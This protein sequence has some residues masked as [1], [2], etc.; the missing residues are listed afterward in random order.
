MKLPAFVVFAALAAA[1]APAR[2]HANLLTNGDFADGLNGWT[3]WIQRD[4]QSDFAATVDTGRLSVAGSDINGGAYQQFDVTP[5]WVVTVTG[6]WHSAPAV[7]DA[8]WAEVLVINA[9]RTPV[10]GVDETGGVNDAILLYKNDTFAGRPA[11]D[12]PIPRTSPV[13]YQISFT[14][15]ASKAT[16]VLKTGNVGPNTFTGVLFDNLE[17]RA[18]PPPATMSDLP[19]GFTGRTYTFPVSNMTSIAQSPVSRHIYAIS[20]EASATNTRLY[21][22]ETDGPAITA[23]LVPGLGNLVDNAQGLTFDPAGNLYISTQFGKIIKGIDTHP[24]PAIDAFAFSTIVTMPPLQIGT[25]HGVGGV[26]VGPD[27]LL[28]INSGS[29]S[30]YGFLSDGSAE[31]FEGRLNARILRCN[32]DGSGLETFCEGIRNSFDITFRMDGKLFGVENGPN[33]GCDYAD[34]FN[35]LEAGQHYGFPYRY[36]SDVSGSDAS[37]TCTSVGTPGPPPLPDGLATTPAWANYGPDGKPGPGELGYADGGP[38]HGFHPHSSPNGL[39]FYEPALMDPGAILFP[40]EFHGRAFVARFGNLEPVP[41]VGF[42]VLTLRLDEAGRGFT[43]NRF[44]GG[45]GRV[46][47]VLCAYN[48]K[49]YV[50]EYNQE[51]VCCFG[52][53]GTPSRLYEIAYTVPTVPLIGLSTSALVRSVDYTQNLPDDTFTVANTGVGTVHFTASSDQAW[54]AVSPTNGSSTGPGDAVTLTLS[55]S[56]AALAIGTH[57]AS[58]TIADPGAANSPQVLSV[59]LT[60]KSVR[61]DFDLDSDVDLEDFAYLQRCLGPILGAPPSPGCE[62]ADID[63]DN[64]VD[65]FDV[66]AFQDCMSGANV[67]ANP[68][69][70]DAY[71]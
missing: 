44:L 67:L 54:L 58:I 3:V 41:E 57:H 42:D 46:V 40:P 37:Y 34:E 17:V 35:M 30:H 22:I 48:G 27:G 7:P 60:V 5:G 20:N 49:V 52:S 2:S 55:Y 45:L 9:D 51:T 38:Y 21:R 29:E 59:T 8:M 23:S 4:G 31:I 11:W 25:F 43:S 18:V 71:E 65:T 63:G 61:P 50:L 6:Y 12:G 69:C 10:D 53:W 15:T 19:A 56:T 14:A 62:P 64:D 16:L 70:D 32:L 1:I 26:A 33:L 28:Y 36:G 39:D 24:D 13:Q 47:D 66:T 68:T